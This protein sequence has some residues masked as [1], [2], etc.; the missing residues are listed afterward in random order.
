L[1]LNPTRKLFSRRTLVRRIQDKLV[2]VEKKV[3]R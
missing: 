2:Q 1:G 3:I